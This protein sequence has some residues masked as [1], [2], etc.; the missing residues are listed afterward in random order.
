MN[1][2][3]GLILS[4]LF[5]FIPADE[6]LR[7]K[8]ERMPDLPSARRNLKAVCSL[9]KLHALGGYAEPFEGPESSHFIFD[10]RNGSEEAHTSG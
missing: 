3:S 1:I 5:G 10:L 8:W 2:S 9:S 4:L 6:T 7:I